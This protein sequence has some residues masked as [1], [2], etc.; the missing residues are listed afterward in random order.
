[1]WAMSYLR[2]PLTRNQ[3]KRLSPASDQAQPLTPQ[4]SKA[5]QGGGSAAGARPVLAAGIDEAFLSDEPGR[6]RPHLLASVSLHYS[7]ASQGLDEWEE[8]LLLAPLEKDLAWDCAE[9]LAPDALAL[10]HDAPNQAEFVSPPSGSVGKARFRTYGKEI[11]S[12]LYQTRPKLLWRNKAL[13]LRSKPGESK[14]EF[15]ARLQLAR[16]EK[17]DAAAEKLRE[18]FA[19]KVKSMQARVGRAEDKVDR[20]QSQYDQQKLQ[21]GISMGAT[22]LGAIFGSRAMGRATTAARGAG[23]V[24]RV[25]EDVQRA[26]EDLQELQDA[27]RE[28]EIE[29]EEEVKALDAEMEREAPELE[30]VIVR[31]KKSDIRVSDLRLAWKPD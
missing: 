6:Y 20:E 9:L 27:L 29:A 16:R 25:R 24:A 23:R 26:E 28:L 11:K 3:I 5:K 12:H 30:E 4:I 10:D 8:H 15:S 14:A 18:K 31:P 22:V 2:G 7:R 21:T 17:R 19:K 1:R 13:K